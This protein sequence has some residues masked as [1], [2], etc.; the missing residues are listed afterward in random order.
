MGNYNHPEELAL[1]SA[2]L[3]ADVFA[4]VMADLPR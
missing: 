3:L 1:R 4:K 2:R